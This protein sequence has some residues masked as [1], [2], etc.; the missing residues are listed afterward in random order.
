MTNN[1][2]AAVAALGRLDGTLECL[3]AAEENGAA[4]R[5]VEVERVG[6]VA[7]GDAFFDERGGL[8]AEHGLVDDDGAA[9][10]EEVGGESA[11][12]SAT[13]CKSEHKEERSA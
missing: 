2:L 1:R 5:A 13:D 11:V 3:G 8:A 4:V 12:V 6:G 9:D 7:E 10:E